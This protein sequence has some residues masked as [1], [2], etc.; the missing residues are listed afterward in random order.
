MFF[1]RFFAQLGAAPVPTNDIHVIPLAGDAK[2]NTRK[3][4]KIKEILRLAKI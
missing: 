4:F 1:E 2:F 3:N